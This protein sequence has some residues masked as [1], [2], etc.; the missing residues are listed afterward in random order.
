MKHIFVILYLFSSVSNALAAPT[1]IVKPPFFMPGNKCPGKGSITISIATGGSNPY[2]NFNGVIPTA[3]GGINIPNTPLGDHPSFT[4]G[5]TDPAEAAV[6]SELCSRVVAI[7]PV[8]PANCQIK[9]TKTEPLLNLTP[10]GTESNITVSG[11]T[12][13]LIT[14]A[15]RAGFTCGFTCDLVSPSDQAK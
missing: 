6:E 15:P 13:T 2:P 12:I 10:L 4:G 9:A 11:G 1:L 7:K 3:G 8:C 14:T 5:G